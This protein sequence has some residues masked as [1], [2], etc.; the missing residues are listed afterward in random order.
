MGYNLIRAIDTTQ[1]YC[2]ILEYAFLP[3][4]RLHTFVPID[5]G[6]RFM[7]GLIVKQ[8]RIVLKGEPLTGYE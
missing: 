1:G 8:Q 5:L 2:D 3:P 6:L 4:V 7:I